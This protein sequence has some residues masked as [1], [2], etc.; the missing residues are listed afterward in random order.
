MEVVPG[1]DR[2]DGPVR[3]AR[4]AADLL[5]VEAWLDRGGRLL[6]VRVALDTA[7]WEIRLSDFGSVPP[8]EAPVA[9]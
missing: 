8:L 5:P 1:R 2:V 6:R 9:V 7:T 3:K 4:A